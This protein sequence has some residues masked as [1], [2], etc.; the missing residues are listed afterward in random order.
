M[1]TRDKG[2]ESEY[3]RR[4]HLTRHPSSGQFK[5]NLI[6]NMIS[7]KMHHY[8]ASSLFNYTFFPLVAY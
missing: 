5:H 8:W 7:G 3:E 1:Q 2:I 4:D 6:K